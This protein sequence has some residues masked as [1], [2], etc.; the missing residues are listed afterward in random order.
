MSKNIQSLLRKTDKT[1]LQIIRYFVVGG[2][3]F[4]VD[5]ITLFILTKYIGLYYLLSATISFLLGLIIN[6]IISINWV[7]SKRTLRNVKHEFFIFT[8]IGII[9]LFFNNIIIW[10][11]TE[12]I[13]V[14]Y[15]YSKIIAA[16]IVLLWNFFARKLILFSKDSK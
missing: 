6:Y 16:I 3:A 12:F 8:V 2:I 14:F 15:L 5:F 7:F 1:S 11:F 13:K 4:F 10:F 9:G